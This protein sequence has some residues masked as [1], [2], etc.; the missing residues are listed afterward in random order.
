LTRAASVW[1]GDGGTVVY[2]VAAAAAFSNRVAVLSTI[3]HNTSC[4]E[5]TWAYRLAPWMSSARAMSRTLVP[6]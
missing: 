1:V 2:V 3:D 4:F 6:E 5:A